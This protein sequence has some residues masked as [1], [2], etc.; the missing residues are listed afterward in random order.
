M[1]L[2]SWLWINEKN[3]YSGGSN[4]ITLEAEFTLAGS[5][6]GSQ[7]HRIWYKRG[8][9]DGGATEQG[10]K[11]CFEMLRVVPCWQAAR[12]WGPQSYSP[13]NWIESAAWMSFDA[14]SF[15]ESPVD[16]CP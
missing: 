6:K 7:R 12:K 9:W 16:T 1:L 11:S 5:R 14:A 10:P 4:P 15:L 8:Y 3:N 2:F 13:R